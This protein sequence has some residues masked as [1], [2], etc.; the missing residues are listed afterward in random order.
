MLIQP[1][2]VQLYVRGKLSYSESLETNSPSY[3]S[4]TGVGKSSLLL[5][6]ADN[7][8]SGESGQQSTVVPLRVSNPDFVRLQVATS[9]RSA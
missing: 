5:R 1:G 9:P 6:F 4:H 7:T 3:F 8:F 2:T